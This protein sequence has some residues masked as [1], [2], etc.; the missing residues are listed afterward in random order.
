MFRWDV[1]CGEVL[2]IIK[3]HVL[4][5]MGC[6]ITRLLINCNENL[7][8]WMCRFNSYGCL[9]CVKLL[10]QTGYLFWG[11]YFSIILVSLVRL[12]TGTLCTERVNTW[13]WEG[14]ARLNIFKG[15]DKKAVKISLFL[16]R[17]KWVI[18]PRV[19]RFPS[20]SVEQKTIPQ[21]S[22]RS[23]LTLATS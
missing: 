15:V 1:S 4:H 11:K 8:H 12:E 18:A 2:G 21:L 7:T 17:E 13:K 10:L 3:T 5:W 14:C 19:Q 16:R 20:R 9:T 22:N 23:V 6:F